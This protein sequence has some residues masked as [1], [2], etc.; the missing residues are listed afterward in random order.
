MNAETRPGDAT[1]RGSMRGISSARLVFLHSWNE[2]CEGTYLEPD[3]RYGRHLLEETRAAVE[4]LSNIENNGGDGKVAAY[5]FRLMREKDEGASR[6]LQAM[7]QQNMYVYREVEYQR[8]QLTILK[9]Q[10]AKQEL[11]QAE[12]RAAIR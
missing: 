6:S 8:E 1:Q 5:L 11:E 3:G 2:W 12:H 9:Q 7:R 10:A 4:E